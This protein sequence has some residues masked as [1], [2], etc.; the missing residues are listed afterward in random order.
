MR[1]KVYSQYHLVRQLRIQVGIP[2]D[3]GIGVYVC[4]KRI[5]LTKRRPA[6]A[7]GVRE[8]ESP[9]GRGVVPAKNRWKHIEVFFLS[10]LLC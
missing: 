10:Y 5:Q 8:C 1:L 9:G 7:A 6:N 3:I 2:H 4:P